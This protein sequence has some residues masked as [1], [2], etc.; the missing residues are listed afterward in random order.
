MAN[1]CALW[2][3]IRLSLDEILYVPFVIFGATFV[4]KCFRVDRSQLLIVDKYFL[5]SSE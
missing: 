3:E 1:V 5:V 4:V 2:H